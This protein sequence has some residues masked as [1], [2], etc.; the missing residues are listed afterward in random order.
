MNRIRELRKKRNMTQNDLAKQLGV[1]PQALGNY[2]RG[3]RKVNSEKLEKL[4]KIFG[5]STGYLLGEMSDDVI[6]EAMMNFY[7][8]PE[9]VL[10]KSKIMA[11]KTEKAPVSFQQHYREVVDRYFIGNGIISY[12]VERATALNSDQAT[13]LDFW[14]KQFGWLL[15]KK[16]IEFIKKAPSYVSKF[17]I[18][19]TCADIVASENEHHL[20]PRFTYN[21][22]ENRFTAFESSFMKRIMR[23]Q[24]FLIVNR[25]LSD[26]PTAIDENGNP[27]YTVKGYTWEL[28]LPTNKTKF[29]IE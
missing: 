20:F 1:S 8:Q 18:V 17:D 6:V 21:K 24:V 13:D 27:A 16:E 2:E 19:E 5:V 9:S 12:D 11:G 25:V 15:Q 29:E 23:R 10:D 14:R 22:E 7:S 28:G 4:A 26:E 3:S